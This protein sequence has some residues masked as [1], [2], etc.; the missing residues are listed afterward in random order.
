MAVS[1]FHTWP[2]PLIGAVVLATLIVAT[3]VGY[4]G[5][6][7][8]AARRGKERKSGGAA[9][10]SGRDYL[11][12]AML[13]LMALLLGFTFSLAFNR[14][15]ARRDLVV[16]E[17]NALE[18]AWQHMKLL[19]EPDR[20]AVQ[21]LLRDY[22]ET[23]SHWSETYAGRD[24]FAPTRERQD[25]LWDA[26]GAAARAEPSVAVGRGLLESLGTSFDMATARLAGRST[27]IPDHVLNVLLL[28]VV[29]AVVLL[30]EV[31]ATRDGLHRPST[32]LLL[33]LLTLALLIILDLD[34]TSEGAIMVSQQ[35]L[36]DLR[37]GMK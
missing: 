12:T 14:F 35:P 28:Y 1:W 33:V 20:S 13:G 23:R 15:E 19:Q 34:R 37:A 2:L 18:A 6:R 24:G 7:W 11:L 4:W 21:A 22:V 36:L 27:N 10:G 9:N 31:S 5:S 26:A 25:K 29:L 3:E 16:K 32:W 30:G 17:A 8:I